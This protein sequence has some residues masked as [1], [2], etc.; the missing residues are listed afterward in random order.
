M[1]RSFALI[2]EMVNTYFKPQFSLRDSW[3][4]SD[5]ITITNTLYLSLGT[6][7][8]DRPRYSLRNGNLITENDVE[9]NPGMFG[10]DEIGQIN[11]QSIYNENTKPINSGFG[12]VSPIDTAYS[13][14]LYC[15]KNYMVQSNNNHVWYG[16]LSTFT[17]K[18][19]KKIEWTG[20]IDLR[21]YTAQ[22]YMEITDLLGGDYA[23]DVRD[24]RNDYVAD[25]SLAMKRVGDKVIRSGKRLFQ[26]RQI[27][28]PAFAARL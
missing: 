28:R 21:S 25:R 4:L 14:K 27:K 1:P 17:N 20:G 12:M 18:I 23:I 8:G 10:R 15:A 11:W 24:L 13:A 16:L 22:H 19:N 26:P 6:G 9:N 5:R 7:G 3:N 2:S